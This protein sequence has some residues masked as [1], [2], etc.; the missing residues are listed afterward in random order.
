[1]SHLILGGSHGIGYAYAAHLAR[2]GSKLHLVARNEGDLRTAAVSLES[3]GAGSVAWDSTD[4]LSSNLT[5]ATFCS[6]SY[7]SVFIGGPSPPPGTLPDLSP[8]ALGKAFHVAVVYPFRVLAWCQ[9]AGLRPGGT[10]IVLSSSASQ[11]PLSDHQFFPSALSRRALDSLVECLRTPFAE[12]GLQLLI[13]RP[14]VVWTRLSKRYAQSLNPGVHDDSE[15]KAA[16]SAR[17]GTPPEDPASY[18]ENQ[19]PR[20]RRQPRHA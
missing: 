5:A 19:L 8:E 2:S 15:L 3:Q 9:T 14:V 4:V 13:W 1:M 10:A 20:L 18:V 12:T 7:D 6:A 16:L 11:E 17:F